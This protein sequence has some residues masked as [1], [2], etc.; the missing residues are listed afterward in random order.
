MSLLHKTSRSHLTYSLHIL[1]IALR[2][3][4]G[5]LKLMVHKISKAINEEDTKISE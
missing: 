5:E 4:Q 1:L 3:Y 2:E